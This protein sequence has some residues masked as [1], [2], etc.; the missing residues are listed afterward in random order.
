MGDRVQKKYWWKREKAEAT[1]ESCQI[2]S[3]PGQL[4]AECGQGRLAY[5]GLFILTCDH[6][7]YVA[8][9]GAFS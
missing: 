9:S 1:N 5:D 7:G 4:C 6:C 8:E 2:P 3:R